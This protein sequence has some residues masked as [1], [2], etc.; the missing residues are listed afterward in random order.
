MRLLTS[1][2]RPGTREFGSS[3]RPVA[4][5][6]QVE[7]HHDHT[8]PPWLF[9]SGETVGGALHVS[10]RGDVSSSVPTPSRVEVIEGRQ[11]E[12]EWEDGSTTSMSAASLRALCACASCLQK[13]PE[14]RTARAHA[15]AR[16]DSAS[17]VGSYAI[18]FVFSPD[19]HTAG[20]F[21]FTG[22]H[23]YGSE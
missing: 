23:G 2:S 7:L 22:L 5:V 11:I 20:I 1:R 3:Q 19:S 10:N 17:F 16:I 21:P 18:S 4:M 12:I 14:E 15:A 8:D 13:P 9:V 6:R